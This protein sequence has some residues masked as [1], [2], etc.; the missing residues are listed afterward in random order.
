MTNDPVLLG[1]DLV[2]LPR[3]A[4]ALNRHGTRFAMRVLTPLE[5]SHWIQLKPERRQVQWLAGRIATKEALAKALGVG[6]NG[7]GWGAG[8]YWQDVSILPQ[9]NAPPRV[10]WSQDSL[11]NTTW[12]VSISHDGDYASAVVMG[13][14]S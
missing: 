8:I 12:Q 14:S 3:I 4:K 10:Q 2:H 7:L 6:L 9:D 13:Q 11:S 5:Y 1:H